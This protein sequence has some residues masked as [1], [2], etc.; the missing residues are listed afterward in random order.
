MK[1]LLLGRVMGGLVSFYTF[2]ISNFF[3][4]TSTHYLHNYANKFNTTVWEQ[5]ITMK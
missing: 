2:A 3:L 4:A 1:L 5:T